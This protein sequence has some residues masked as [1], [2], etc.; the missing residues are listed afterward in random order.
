M[1]AY[2]RGR[3]K[4]YD[5]MVAENGRI[6]GT[7]RWMGDTYV[8][9]FSTLFSSPEAALVTTLALIVGFFTMGFKKTMLTLLGTPLAIGLAEKADDAWTEDYR[10]D[11]MPA[12]PT[13]SDKSVAETRLAIHT[14][15]EQADKAQELMKNFTNTNNAEILRYINGDKTA[16]ISEAQK[17]ILDNAE[18]ANII[19]TD[20][21]G[22]RKKVYERT[23]DVLQQLNVP[24][25][26]QNDILQGISNFTAGELINL[27][28]M[29]DAEFKE[30]VKNREEVYNAGILAK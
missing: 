7:M 20:I 18:S 8:Q 23:V 27:A 2:G 12:V 13:A 6:G 4:S 5:E 10:E 11:N 16:K 22:T 14:T 3:Q 1:G 17:A 30:D 29:T 19:K 15:Q 9:G 21:E 24:V 25:T 28:S 26:K